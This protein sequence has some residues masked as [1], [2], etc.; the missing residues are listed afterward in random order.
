MSKV[1]SNYFS[2]QG[3]MN[4]AK[5]FWI[6]TLILVVEIVL[7]NGVV[8]S[9]GV[10]TPIDENKTVV[11]RL[12]TTGTNWVEDESDKDERGV[13]IVGIVVIIILMTAF[14]LTLFPAVK[15]AHD[16]NW[17]GW[18]LLLFLIPVFNIYFGLQ[19]IFLKGTTGINGY[20]E[21]PLLRPSTVL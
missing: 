20:G 16:R 6:T 10:L 3:R 13:I 21:D 7:S 8:L 2:F 17:T 11:M 4:R 5:Y 18:W 14:V 9:S 1:I 12:D 15:R 19:L